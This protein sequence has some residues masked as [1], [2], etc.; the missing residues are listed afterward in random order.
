MR[1]PFFRDLCIRQGISQYFCHFFLFLP[2][3]LGIRMKWGCKQTRE[4][5]CLVSKIRNFL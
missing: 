2:L 1:T 3:G 4:G 5:V